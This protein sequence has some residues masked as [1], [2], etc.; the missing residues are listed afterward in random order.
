MPD[1]LGPRL[2]AGA[3]CS[4]GKIEFVMKRPREPKAP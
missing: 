1:G 4:L 3:S 2:T